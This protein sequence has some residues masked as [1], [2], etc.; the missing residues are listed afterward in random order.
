MTDII[1]GCIREKKL[2]TM[3]DMSLGD[4]ARMRLTAWSCIADEAVKVFRGEL[5]KAPRT[6]SSSP[7]AGLHKTQVG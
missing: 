7:K 1:F 4:D 5:L 6:K 2:N 3:T